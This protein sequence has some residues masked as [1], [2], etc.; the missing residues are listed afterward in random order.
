MARMSFDERA[1]SVERAVED[2]RRSLNPRFFRYPDH[3]GY[4][5]ATEELREHMTDFEQ[6]KIQSYEVGN[7]RHYAAH[8]LGPKA[9]GGELSLNWVKLIEHSRP[10]DPE[11]GEDYI[12]FYSNDLIADKRDLRRSRVPIVTRQGRDSD[13]DW[14]EFELSAGHSARLVDKRLTEIIREKK[15]RGEVIEVK[16]ERHKLKDALDEIAKGDETNG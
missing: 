9:V 3:I 15:L 14:I 6:L 1:A 7:Q 10:Q 12:A 2:L 11:A 13:M 16:T 8:L 4:S 5:V